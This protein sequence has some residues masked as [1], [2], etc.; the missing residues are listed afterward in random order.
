MKNGQIYV[1][2]AC[3]LNAGIT[4]EDAGIGL[5]NA[6][7]HLQRSLHFEVPFFKYTK[8]CQI[9]LIDSSPQAPDK[10]LLISH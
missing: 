8:Q 7:L 10:K 3:A 9:A 4:L 5:A 2:G 1:L 6:R